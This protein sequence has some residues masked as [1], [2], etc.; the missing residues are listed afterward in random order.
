MSK[1]ELNKGDNFIFGVD[2]SA[3]MMTADCPGETQRIEYLKEAVIVFAKEASK[4]DPDGIDIL[5]FGATV[6]EFNAVTAENAEGVISS[7]RANEGATKTH[8]LIDKAWEKHRLGG[9]EQT[10]LFVATD[11]EPT[12][13]EAVEGVIRKIAGDLRD[14]HEF[15]I[16]ILT[17][18]TPSEQLSAWLRKLDDTLNAKFDIVDVRPLEGTSFEEAFSGALHD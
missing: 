3:S 6:R 7:L 2:V 10:V 8:L 13:P 4:Y 1:L 11:G 14:E 17:V 16:S 5:T 18:G 12:D 15:G 9:Y